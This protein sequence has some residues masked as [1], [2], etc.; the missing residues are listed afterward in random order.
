ML[1]GWSVEEYATW[2]ID[3]LGGYEKRSLWCHTGKQK[4]GWGKENYTLL[5]YKGKMG[6]IEAKRG[7]HL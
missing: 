2:Q 3:E 5:Y 4:S 1:V 7:K 6:I